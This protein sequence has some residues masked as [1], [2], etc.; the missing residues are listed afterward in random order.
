MG[1]ETEFVDPLQVRQGGSRDPNKQKGTVK[2]SN[3]VKPRANRRLRHLHL[4]VPE[5]EAICTASVRL[6]TT[7]NEINAREY[8]PCA[9][10]TCPREFVIAYV[11]FRNKCWPRGWGH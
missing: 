11:C 5:C 10:A 1:R 2:G 4:A 7:N 8:L 9:A 3:V 6:S